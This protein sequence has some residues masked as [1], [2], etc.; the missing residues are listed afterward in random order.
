RSVGA[1]RGGQQ[2]VVAEVVRRAAVELRPQLLVLGETGRGTSTVGRVGDDVGDLLGN[3][4]AAMAGR[5]ADTRRGVRAL[6]DRVRQLRVDLARQQ[7]HAAGRLLRPLF[8]RREVV[9]AAA[10]FLHVEM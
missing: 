8:I 9:A 2:A 4:D 6:A 7:P 10:A 1:L 3:G 5:A